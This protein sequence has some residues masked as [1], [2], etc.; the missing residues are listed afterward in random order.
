[1]VWPS[2]MLVHSST[3]HPAEVQHTVAKILGLSDNAVTVEVRSIGGGFGGKESQ[4]ALI[5]GIARG[6]NGFDALD[7]IR[8]AYQPGDS[9][10]VFAFRLRAS[11][12]PRLEPML[13][14]IRDLDPRQFATAT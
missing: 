10:A 11:I 5:A 9:L 8:H 4:P 14:I 12:P 7:E 13:T 6:T 1:M 2:D 3:Q